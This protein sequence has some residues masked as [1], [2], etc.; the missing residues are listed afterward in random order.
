MKKWRGNKEKKMENEEIEYKK[1]IGRRR[2]W[3]VK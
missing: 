1:K 2:E 3:E